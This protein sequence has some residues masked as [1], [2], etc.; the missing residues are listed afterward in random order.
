M[1]RRLEDLCGIDTRTLALFRVGLA[2]LLLYDVASRISNVRVHYTD[3]GMVPWAST[4]WTRAAN[5]W[6][7]S[8]HAAFDGWGWPLALFLLAG[9][10]AL[11][12]L[13][14]YR[15]RV[16]TVASWIL[17]ASVQTRNPF[18]L[19]GGDQILL[20]L[21]FWSIFLPLGAAFSVDRAL[22]EPIRPAPR[23]VVSMATLAIV[24]QVAMVYGFSAVLKDHPSW[25]V[26]R[27]AVYEALSIDLTTSGAGVF[28]RGFPGFLKVLTVGTLVVEFCAPIAFFCPVFTGPVRTAAAFSLILMHV[29]FAV[30]MEIGSFPYVGMVACS[31]VLPSWFWD[32]V[33]L[34]GTAAPPEACR[35]YYDGE[36]GFCRKMVHLLRT[37]LG[38]PEVPIV[39]AQEDAETVEVLRKENSWV[40]MDGEGKRRLRYDGFAYLASV[41]PALRPVARLVRARPLSALGEKLY[42]W[43]AGHRP[44]L[45]RL[46]SWLRFRREREGS[47]GA[48]RSALALVS[49]VAVAGLIAYVFLWNLRTVEWPKYTNVLPLKL[50]FIGQALRLDQKWFLF[51][52]APYKSDGWFV[53]R[54]TLAGGREVDL[55]RGGATV[56]WEKPESI[57]A[58]HPNVRWRK[59]MR[60]LWEYQ[61]TSLPSAY[62]DHLFRDWNGRH[63]GEDRV[64]R[65]EMIYMLEMT[66]EY[67]KTPTVKR[68][69]VY[70]GH[71]R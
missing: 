62:V 51:A 55:F 34:R 7:F 4:E 43:V 41:S 11:A 59:Y 66:E 37:F 56:S 13:V 26:D 24:L 10:F 16:A 71:P 67:P 32:R 42:V 14:G 9:V 44:V 19:H 8:L 58:L 20:L 17:Y 25:T 1:K 27:T 40:V 70:T 38:L 18:V 47:P 65:I 22:L 46:T 61:R 60:N 23:R 68:V 57:S 63:T 29:G 15:T 30:C 21:L 50:G 48:A 64:V 3:W 31:V 35:I 54:G 33:V 69:Q 45:G 49:D 12:L 5:P 52:P 28:L 39:P 53:V 2:S 6:V 36:C